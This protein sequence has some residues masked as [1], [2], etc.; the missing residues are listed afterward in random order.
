[1]LLKA[2]AEHVLASGRLAMKSV[3][4]CSHTRGGIARSR[5][6]FPASRRAVRNARRATRR[7]WASQRAGDVCRDEAFAR[8]LKPGERE[9]A[10]RCPCCDQ[11]CHA[12]RCSLIWIL[13]VGTTDIPGPNSTSG[14]S[15]NTIFTGTRCTILT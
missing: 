12:G 15:S 3:L 11:T 2:V 13:T 5:F 6:T 10:E 8:L 7:T 4:Q 1:M 14:G 9:H